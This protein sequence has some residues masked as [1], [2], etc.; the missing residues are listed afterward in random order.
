MYCKQCFRYACKKGQRERTLKVCGPAHIFDLC[1]RGG[2]SLEAEGCAQL[3]A[4]AELVGHVC[5]HMQQREPSHSCGQCQSNEQNQQHQHAAGGMRSSSSTSKSSSS[6]S[7][8]L[9]MATCLPF[10]KQA[11]GNADRCWPTG[12]RHA[13]PI[14]KH[15]V[16][17]VNSYIMPED[18]AT[19]LRS[20]GFNM[21]S[22]LHSPCH[23][24]GQQRP[25]PALSSRTLLNA[26]KCCCSLP[27]MLALC[28]PST[29][30]CNF[31]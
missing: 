19:E 29:A 30:F 20:Q 26:L 1:A 13:L 11:V 14:G 18:A 27:G 15:V 22:P 23:Q 7:S 25:S 10:C 17:L 8:R 21:C 31:S 3:D 4:S 6:S 16:P 28:N 24:T 5:S 12:N 9:C 2:K